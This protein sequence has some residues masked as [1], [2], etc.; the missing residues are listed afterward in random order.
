MLSGL[1]PTIGDGDS[2]L[3]ACGIVGA[4]VMP[5][6][7]Y[8]HSGL[9]SGGGARALRGLRAD[10][11][12]ALGIAGLANLAML[13]VAASALYGRSGPFDTID[14][15][16]AGLAGVL[17]PLVGLVF[18]LA[19]LVAGLASACVGTKSGELVMSGFLGTR[20]PT[21]VRRLV[22]MT[23]ALVVLCI[24]VDPTTALVVS[25]VVLSFGLPFA[26]IP[27]VVLTSRP[28]VMG[29]SV[30]RRATVLLGVVV[31]AF[32]CGLNM[33]LVLQA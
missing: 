5:H 10:I 2:V 14:Q 19:L 13:I 29:K 26:L 11:P 31:A 15:I 21:T 3:L 27:L 1:V 20:I 24:G 30:N 4:R 22:T 16:Q 18:A 7:V 25:Q 8:L 9:T 12:V 32:V 33:V 23:P 17:G 28:D 6:A